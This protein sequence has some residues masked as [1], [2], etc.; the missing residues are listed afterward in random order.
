MSFACRV[1]SGAG[2][3]NGLCGLYRLQKPLSSNDSRPLGTIRRQKNH[4]VRDDLE[5]SDNA[6]GEARTAPP[7][8][9]LK[10]IHVPPHALDAMVTL[11]LND[12]HR[13]AA[14]VRVGRAC[15]SQSACW[16]QFGITA[17][18]STDSLKIRLPDITISKPNAKL[19]GNSLILRKP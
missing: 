19:A 6:G 9:A 18:K 2:I 13:Q 14:E 3:H 5:D 15:L 4:Q 10:L 17:G 12:V 16:L 7:S 1:E 11:L 8:G